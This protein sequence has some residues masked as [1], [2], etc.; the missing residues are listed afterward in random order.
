ML[1]SAMLFSACDS[2]VFYADTQRVDESGWN[3]AKSVEFDVEVPDTTTYYHFM[4]DLR[5]TNTYEYANAFLFINTTFPDG[6]VAHDTLECPLADVT[7]QW[8]GKR[9]GQYINNRYFFRKYVSFPMPGNYHFE[10][11][12]G[13]READIKGI[14]N[15]GL[16]IEYAGKK[17]I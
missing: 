11:L 6:S 5:N 3:M 1:M 14:K 7:G 10:I 12:H 13:M 17:Q 16:R 8:Y 4:I 15:I 9:S 2:K